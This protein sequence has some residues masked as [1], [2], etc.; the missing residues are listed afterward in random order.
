MSGFD[1]E[2]IKLR[3]GVTPTARPALQILEQANKEERNSIH[4]IVRL[5]CEPTEKS[6][7]RY[8]LRTSCNFRSAG[9]HAKGSKPPTRH[10]AALFQ[11]QGT[12]KKNAERELSTPH[13]NSK[14]S[15]YNGIFNDSNEI[16]K[17]FPAQIHD[18][19][20]RYIKTK[21][22]DNQQGTQKEQS[23]VQSPSNK[24]VFDL[25]GL[26]TNQENLLDL[27]RSLQEQQQIRVSQ[28]GN[29]YFLGT[30]ANVSIRNLYPN[31]NI[32]NP[33]SE[34][35]NLE[36]RSSSLQQSLAK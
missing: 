8:H 12:V 32:A 33:H 23:V 2:S 14:S 22:K 18:T 19:L 1:A 27:E 10:S 5:D 25:N 34:P 7:S 15:G 26:S 13:E 11:K 6:S 16:K 29:D 28:H 4:K 20:L 30:L 21:G 36:D 24:H 9:Q 35:E 31:T 3:M 17:D